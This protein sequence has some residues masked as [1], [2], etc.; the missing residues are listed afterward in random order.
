MGL[1]RQSNLKGN[2][3]TLSPVWSTSALVPLGIT[4]AHV[5]VLTYSHKHTHGHTHHGHVH[6]ITYT[7]NHRDGAGAQNAFFHFKKSDPRS[8]NSA[9]KVCLWGFPK[10]DPLEIF[11]F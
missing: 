8:L 9:A 6:T 4:G 7:H 10:R 1:T 2:V 5:C 3:L 11:F